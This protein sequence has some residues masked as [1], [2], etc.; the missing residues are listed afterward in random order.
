[1]VSAPALTWRVP[2]EVQQSNTRCRKE[3]I[4]TKKRNLPVPYKCP[5]CNHT[6]VAVWV[7]RE[8]RKDYHWNGQKYELTKLCEAMD[9][10]DL[11]CARCGYVYYRYAEEDLISIINGD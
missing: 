8:I 9:F 5:L 10:Y 3:V 1:M 11:E 6:D 4:Y 7:K 2:P